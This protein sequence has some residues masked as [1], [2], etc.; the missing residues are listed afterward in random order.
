MVNSFDLWP[1]AELSSLVRVHASLCKFGNHDEAQPSTRYSGYMVDLKVL[2]EEHVAGVHGSTSPYKFT[3]L[4]AKCALH[5]H[6]HILLQKELQL[7][8]ISK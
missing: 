3:I 8:V 1:L 5:L 4:S 2:L 7:K 6:N